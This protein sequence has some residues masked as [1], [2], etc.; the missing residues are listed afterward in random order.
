MQLVAQALIE[1]EATRAI[2]AGRDERSAERLTHRNGARE[3][4]LSIKAGDLELRM[5]KLRHGSFS[6]CCWSGAGAPTGPSLIVIGS[7]LL[8][9]TVASIVKSRRD[10]PA[11][12]HTGSLR[13]GRRES[14][15]PA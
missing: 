13:E 9:T 1:L 8:M 3:R 7:V 10:P 4:T 12:A 14:P 11:R 2:G 15:P 6:P 5:P